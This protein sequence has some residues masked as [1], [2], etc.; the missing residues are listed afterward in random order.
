M[1]KINDT[2]GHQAGDEYLC[3]FVHRTKKAIR[4]EDILC[5]F[6][7]DEFVLLFPGCSREAAQHRM[8]EIRY[9]LGGNSQQ[10][11]FGAGV[12]DSTESSHLDTLIRIADQRMYEE[13]RVGKECEEH[14]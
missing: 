8:E 7:G 12:V 11:A 6:G 1:K 14:V 4:S 2:L 9:A 10:F 5:R 13:K 3:Q